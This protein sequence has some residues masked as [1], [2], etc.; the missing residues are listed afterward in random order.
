MKIASRFPIKESNGLLALVTIIHLVVL[1]LS[2]IIIEI[3][4]QFSFAFAGLLVSYYYSIKQLKEITLA[5][6]DLCWTGDQWLVTLLNDR[7]KLDYRETAYLRILASSWITSWF[8][9][10]KFRIESINGENT[11]LVWF[12]SSAS[13]GDRLY[14]ELC[15]LCKQDLKEQSKENGNK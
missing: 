6:D 9:L 5:P 3:L 1:I 8:S 2:F 14:R 4:W 15:Y 10:L 7:N 12:F 13:L 11:E